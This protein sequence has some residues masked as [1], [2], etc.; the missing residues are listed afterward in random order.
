[1]NATMNYNK[2]KNAF[3]I[4]GTMIDRTIQIVVG[5]TSVACLCYFTIEVITGWL[6]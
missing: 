5:G 3:G 2:S 6:R 4:V 1:M